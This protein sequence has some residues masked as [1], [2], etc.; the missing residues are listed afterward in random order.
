M[1]QNG[2]VPL[3]TKR[4]ANPKEVRT[5]PVDLTEK[6]ISFRAQRLAEVTQ[7]LDDLDEKR[8][9]QNQA[10]YREAKDL[11]AERRAL[12]KVVTT[13]REVREVACE[14]RKDF[15]R[16]CIEVVRLDTGEVVDTHP[17]KAADRQAEIPGIDS[18]TVKEAAPAAAQ[19]T[20]DVEPAPRKP[21]KAPGKNS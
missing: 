7:K 11:N 2:V 6:E 17:M 4:N 13:K 5:L 20:K 15:D 1:A 19:G 9:S 18:G 10:I 8:R 16:N 14:Q 3:D 12:T 21:R